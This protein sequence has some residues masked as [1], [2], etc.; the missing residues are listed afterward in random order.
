MKDF[1]SEEK[2]GEA[3]SSEKR[4]RW[5]RQRFNKGWKG[6]RERKSESGEELWRFEGRMRGRKEMSTQFE[7]KE[8]DEHMD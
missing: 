2:I 5:R 7:I 1:F 6:V 3:E 4:N 8:E